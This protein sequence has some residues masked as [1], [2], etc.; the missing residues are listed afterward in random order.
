MTTVTGFTVPVAVTA[1][2]TAPRVTGAV[3]YWAVASFPVPQ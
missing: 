2:A 3:T 1:T